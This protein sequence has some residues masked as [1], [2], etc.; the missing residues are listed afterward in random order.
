VGFTETSLFFELS[1]RSMARY[2]VSAHSY[3]EPSNVPT[4]TADRSQRAGHRS[5]SQ[6][7]TDSLLPQQSTEV[8]GQ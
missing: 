2:L 3:V 5:L 6:F 7:F 8:I 1:L 4:F